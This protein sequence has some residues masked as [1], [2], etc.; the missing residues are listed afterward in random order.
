MA[1]MGVTIYPLSV[2]YPLLGMHQTAGE[3]SQDFKALTLLT[4]LL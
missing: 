4:S 3:G 2:H 1:L